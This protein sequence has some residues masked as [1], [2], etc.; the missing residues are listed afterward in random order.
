[1]KFQYTHLQQQD[2]IRVFRFSQYATSSFL[3]V[4]LE[5]L[6]GYQLD[7]AH[8]SVVTHGVEEPGNIELRGITLNGRS[9]MIP[10]AL[11]NALSAIVEHHNSGESFWANAISIN[12]GDIEEKQRQMSQQPAVFRSADCVWVWI[13]DQDGSTAT[14]FAALRECAESCPFSSLETCRPGETHVVTETEITR[15]AI[16]QLLQKLGLQ[17]SNEHSK[18]SDMTNH[19][20]FTGALQCDTSLLQHYLRVTRSRL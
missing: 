12:H 2:T 13:D 3:H 20:L 1:M 9:F 16:Q 17:T 19:R 5:H 14:A 7:D 11:W 15:T 8:Y 6:D 18:I 4:W 10:A